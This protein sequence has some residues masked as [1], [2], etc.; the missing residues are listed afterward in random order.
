MSN[1]LGKVKFLDGAVLFF[2]YSG[3]CSMAHTSLYADASHARNQD[4]LPQVKIPC[5]CWDENKCSTQ[6]EPVELAT[7]YCDG[8]H[9]IGR[10]CRACNRITDGIEPERVEKE[11]PEDLSPYYAAEMFMPYSPKDGLPDWW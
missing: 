5:E 7:D 11:E 6:D 9:W 8:K 1:G 3:T 4:L 10:A 2:K